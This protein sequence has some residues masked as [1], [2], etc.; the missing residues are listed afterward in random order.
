MDYETAQEL[1]DALSAPFPAE[2]IDWRVGSTNKDKT[3]GMALAYID[4]RAVMDRLDSMCGP[5]N[6][7]ANY[8]PGVNGS[9]VCNLAIRFPGGEWIWKADG[10]GATD[11]EGEKG[12]LSD[13]FKRAAVRFG[14]GRYLYDLKAPWI[15]IENGKY[16]PDS[17]R[18]KLDEVHEDFA[19]KAGWGQ[20][21]GIQA[22]KLANQ[23][24]EQFVTDAASAQDFK[25]KNAGMIAQLPVAM[26]RHLNEKLDRIGAP[27]MQAAE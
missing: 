12:A 19:H 17:E 5:E 8:T 3:K 26:R 1:F 4:A 15:A 25:D 2:S 13:A 18:K 14:I 7:Q 21:A 20:R 9:I 27:S 22:Y 16:I 23:M 24:V 10:A 11:F 6:W